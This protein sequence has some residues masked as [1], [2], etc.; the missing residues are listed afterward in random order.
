MFVSQVFSVYVLV[1]VSVPRYVAALEAFSSS[2]KIVFGS[3]NR[4]FVQSI[5]RQ[6]EQV[7]PERV[8]LLGDNIYADKKVHWFKFV[9]ASPDEI[10]RH[11]C[12]LN[13]N[14]RWQ[15]FVRSVGGFDN[16][17]A[18]WDDHD[19]GTNDG[20]R[21]Y[22][23]KDAS[24]KL[25]LDFFRVPES[26]PRRHRSGVYDSS[27]HPLRTRPGMPTLYYKIILLDVRYNLNVKGDL[28]ER[29]ILGE[30]Q[31][32][33]LEAELQDEAPFVTLLSSGIQVLPTGKIVEES[34]SRAPEARDRLLRM[35]L[36]AKSR[37]VFI[38]SGDV[39]MAEISQ[40][41]VMLMRKKCIS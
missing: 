29:D 25:F 3:C 38:L 30:E 26:S 28:P 36:N 35:I 8:I 1:C 21:F 16:V 31:W 40:V 23:H 33:W 41:L 18:V 20:D 34:W 4:Q 17:H 9:D 27:I 15:S 39:H 13:G 12:N 19:F 5:W 32:L 7:R 10:Y 24:R 11:Y 6:L 2:T 14:K 37:N 22:A